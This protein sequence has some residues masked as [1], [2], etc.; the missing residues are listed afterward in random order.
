MGHGRDLC[1]LG[2]VSSLHR[3][4]SLFAEARKSPYGVFNYTSGRGG[5]QGRERR[6][7]RPPFVC[8]AAH[9][10]SALDAY[11]SRG[12]WRFSSNVATFLFANTQAPPNIISYGGAGGVIAGFD[13]LTVRLISGRLPLRLGW[14]LGPAAAQE[15]APR[16][17]PG[18]WNDQQPC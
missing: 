16:R 11:R 18:C 4:R 5:G 3:P 1:P 12:A 17:S 9:T 8:D 14:G 13:A 10:R 6:I 2:S 15:L 7:G